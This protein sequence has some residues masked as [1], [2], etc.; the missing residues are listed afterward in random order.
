MV[1]LVKPNGQ[2]E[3]A[4]IGL[5]LGIDF[6]IDENGDL[7]FGLEHKYKPYVIGISLAANNPSPCGGKFERLPQNGLAAVPD[8]YGF[9]TQYTVKQIHNRK[10]GILD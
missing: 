5:T 4:A 10:R 6:S 1:A 8:A 7:H 2:L 3:V 9:E